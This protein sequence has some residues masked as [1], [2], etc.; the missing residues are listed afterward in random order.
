MGW[1]EWLNDRLTDPQDPARIVH[2][3]EEL[4]QTLLLPA[5]QGWTHLEDADI[6]G[7]NLI[8]RMAVYSHR[9][10]GP[11]EVHGGHQPG[12]RSFVVRSWSW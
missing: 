1:V 7:G 3:Q 8:P 5:A 11:V 12:T 2:S 9:H 10:A 4:L 6:L